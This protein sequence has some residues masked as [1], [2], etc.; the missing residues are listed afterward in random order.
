M[1]KFKNEVQEFWYT[2]VDSKTVKG[3]V[4]FGTK[5]I[6]ILGKVVDSLGV[7]GTAMAAAFVIPNLKNAGGGRIKYIKLV[8]INMPPNKLTV[9]WANCDISAYKNGNIKVVFGIVVVI[10]VKIHIVHKNIQIIWNIRSTEEVC[11]GVCIKVHTEVYNKGEY[12]KNKY[13]M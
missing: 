3:F 1:Q 7:V 10:Y 11:W 4:D 13:I 8:L 2:L 12:E 6:D 9:R 5:L